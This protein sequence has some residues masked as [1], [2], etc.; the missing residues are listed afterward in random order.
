MLFACT[1]TKELRSRLNQAKTCSFYAFFACCAHV[2]AYASYERTPLSCCL[3]LQLVLFGEQTLGTRQM[4]DQRLLLT[5]YRY[6][7]M[8]AAAQQLASASALKT[9]HAG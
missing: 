6:Y 3:S 1:G 2:A 4:H 7:W 8:A 5:R 9:R